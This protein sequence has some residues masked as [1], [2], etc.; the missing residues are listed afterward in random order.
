PP[1]RDLAVPE[2][3]RASADDARRHYY[4]LTQLGIWLGG[5]P[6]RV[7]TLATLVVMYVRRKEGYGSPVQ[8]NILLGWMSLKLTL[9]LLVHVVAHPK[10]ILES[11]LQ[12]ETREDKR[13]HPLFGWA[14]WSMALGLLVLL[15]GAVC[16]FAALVILLTVFL[17]V[18]AQTLGPS[19]HAPA[20][21][22]IL[23]TLAWVVSA[24]VALSIA[25]YL[26]VATGTSLVTE[27][28]ELKEYAKQQ[29]RRTRKQYAEPSDKFLR[30][31]VFQPLDMAKAVLHPYEA[32]RQIYDL[33]ADGP[34]TEEED[35]DLLVVCAALQS[36][37]QVI[38]ADS[39]KLVR[40]LTAAIA[41][42]GLYPP[43]E[44][45]PSELV[46]LPKEKPTANGTYQLID[47]A[48]VRSNPLPAFFDWCKV[49]NN[50]RVQSIE[51]ASEFAPSLHVVYGVPI[52]TTDNVASA[53][54]IDCPDIV[55]SAQQ[56]LELEKR[57]DT[58]QEFRQTNYM[59]RLEQVRRK[60][61]GTPPGPR[62]PFAIEA[63]EIA[64]MRDLDIGD[65]LL[66]D[67]KKLLHIVAQGCQATMEALYAVEIAA[68]GYRTECSGL[69]KK[70]T[71]SRTN[72]PNFMPGLPEVCSACTGL[73]TYRK[74]GNADAPPPGV[75]QSY[76]YPASEL[77]AAG[78]PDL[79]KRFE[80]LTTPGP[81]TVFLGSGGVFR[82][83]FHIGVLA[84]MTA[85]EL[86]PDLVIGASVG[87]LMGGALCN[88][89]AGSKA[90]EREVLFTLAA[91]FLNVDEKVALTRT[92]KNASKQLAIRA[93]SIQLS[94]S[95]LA[96][97]IRQGSRDDAGFAATGAPPALIDA[98]SSLFMIP[99]RNT[100]EISSEF[101]AGHVSQASASFLR[102][103][104]K[105][106]LASF[107]VQ[108]AIIGVS[109]LTDQARV[110]LGAGKPEVDLSSV[111]P[112]QGPNARRKVSFFCTTSFLNARTPLLLGRDFLTA[113]PT[114]DG[115]YAG[116]CSSAFPAAFAPREE[117][118]LVPG[119]GRSGRYF[120]D[121]GLFDNLPFFPAIEILSATQLA[122]SKGASNC[123]EVLEQIEARTRK[124]NLF[125]AA[126]LNSLP[127]LTTPCETVFQIKSR[128]DGLSVNN[129]TESF[130]YA[131]RKITNTLGEIGQARM[132]GACVPQNGEPR[133][134]P[135][136]L[137]FLQA[138]VAAEV[139]SILSSDAEHLNPTFAFCRSTGL[140]K[141]RVQRSIADGC[142]Q[143]LKA[144]AA[145]NPRAQLPSVQ[146]IHPRAS[147]QSKNPVQPDSHCPYYTHN[148]TPLVCPFTRA[149]EGSQPKEKLE[150]MD[151]YHQCCNDPV[152]H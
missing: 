30:R 65:P 23:R 44:V 48:A 43:L 1:V 11:Q 148:H 40:A 122:G 74:K 110:L 123:R 17:H 85:V 86:Y 94:P 142:F 76:G 68:A 139:V 18:W 132:A 101:V 61:T 15:G 55:T 126:G 22:I 103:V 33:F 60:A 88:M 127:V 13:I 72:D 150:V 83:A 35:M 87:A 100:A 115:V 50:Q 105:E 96:R 81:K 37:E 147:H 146:I 90:K 12:S 29:A 20:G 106:T 92:L 64:P 125:I 75:M 117:S 70:L 124:P 51:K 41:I 56:A 19:F 98:L 24:T 111:Q 82:G 52:S 6:I 99:R 66:P 79:R 14:L 67:S 26:G 152:H 69:L 25:V 53:P 116:L 71:Q 34:Q 102:E 16:A 108:T 73:L 95:E 109:M 4:L 78:R 38:L 91:V 140:K 49:V 5:L 9:G 58:R 27:W 7:S 8:R 21:S 32:E 42:P 133:L 45:L 120:A 129:K 63:D 131:A 84:A 138:S 3:L 46:K 62:G 89:T 47:G 54:A 36:T 137:R 112:Y 130:R 119:R 10:I 80:H 77:N 59:T 136:D 144:F 57:R 28:K 97:K 31:F 93:R 143:S 135:E 2:Y 118:D 141:D 107:E 128:A 114:W 149:P 39:V 134:S 145:G 104:R 121:G 151:I 113:D